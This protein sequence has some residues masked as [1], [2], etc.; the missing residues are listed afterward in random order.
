MKTLIIH[1][2]EPCWNSSYYKFGTNFEDLEVK[3]S[4][5]IKKNK[6]EKV[7]LTLFEDY[8]IDPYYYP[9]L[10]DLV[11]DVE[12]Y[13]YGWDEELKNQLEEQNETV[14]EGGYHSDYVW[15]PKWVKDLRGPVKLCGAF[16]GECLEDMEIALRAANVKYKLVEKLVVG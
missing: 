3:V 5:W 12:N 6:T 9:N 2:L 16:R 15:V 1:H 11:T 7:I 4:S 10:F 14:V 13:G 8:K